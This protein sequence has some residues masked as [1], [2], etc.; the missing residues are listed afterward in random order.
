MKVSRTPG[1]HDEIEITLAV[2]LFRVLEPVEFLRQRTDRLGQ[3][4]QRIRQ[5]GHSPVR[6]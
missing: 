6:V 4:P 5:Q 1:W 2:A 3:Q